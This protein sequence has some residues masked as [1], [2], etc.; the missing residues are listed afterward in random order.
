MCELSSS[1][2]IFTQAAKPYQEALEKSGYSHKLVYTPPAESNIPNRR[3]RNRKIVWF[4][5]PFSKN[6]ETNL[7]NNFFSLI[8]KHFP[9]GH[10]LHPVLD[11][12]SVKISYS[13]LSNIKNIISKHNAK[14]LREEESDPPKCE[15]DPKNAQIRKSAK[16]QGLSTRQLYLMGV[17]KWK[18][19]WA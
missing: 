12:N 10:A 9:K 1:E 6:V 7:G 5:P 4:N 16:L 3:Q 8:E 14:I 18:N 15:C 19:M 2:E 11:K 17:I 13:C